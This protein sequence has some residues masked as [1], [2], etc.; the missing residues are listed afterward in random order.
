MRDQAS[1][2]HSFRGEIHKEKNMFFLSEHVALRHEANHAVVSG[3]KT[4]RF[5]RNW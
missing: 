5:A 4:A 3:V 1:G 2:M